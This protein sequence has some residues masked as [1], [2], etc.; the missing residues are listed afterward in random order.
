M[1]GLVLINFK[2]AT[3]L[4]QQHVSLLLSKTWKLHYEEIALKKQ[5]IFLG[6]WL[7]RLNGICSEAEMPALLC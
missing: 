7:N 4:L 5:H 1:E 3:Y 6:S 2:S